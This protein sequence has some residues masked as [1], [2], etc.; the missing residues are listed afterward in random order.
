MLKTYE[1]I[2]VDF[3]RLYSQIDPNNIQKLYLLLEIKIVKKSLLIRI[4]YI[5]DEVVYLMIDTLSFLS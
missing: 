2:K 4:K 5:I 1:N 3:L